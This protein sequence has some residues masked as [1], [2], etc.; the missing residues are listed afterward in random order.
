LL[1]GGKLRKRVTWIKE[2]KKGVLKKKKKGSPRLANGE[3]KRKGTQG[4][5]GGGGKLP[6]EVLSSLGELAKASN[7][8]G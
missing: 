6:G 2:K 5:R 3:G 7:F 8:R 1:A 4:L